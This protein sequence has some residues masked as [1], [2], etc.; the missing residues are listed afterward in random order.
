MNGEDHLWAQ[1]DSS[2]GL[3]GV[4]IAIDLF[5]PADQAPVDCNPIG[6]RT[7]EEG[8]IATDGDGF[9]VSDIEALGQAGD[10][11]A[12]AFG[13]VLGAG[14]SPEEAWNLVFRDTTVTFV[15]TG[16]DC[17]NIGIYYFTDY[18]FTSGCWAA[19]G[20]DGNVY[21]STEFSNEPHDAEDVVEWGS[22]ETGLPSIQV[23]CPAGSAPP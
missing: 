14:Y 6:N 17:Y 22:H 10:N 21:V 15:F 12:D 2:T 3:V 18:G 11:I 5:S 4:W 13:Y 23:T 20:R 16:R 1:V 8:Y 19:A 7:E 9:T